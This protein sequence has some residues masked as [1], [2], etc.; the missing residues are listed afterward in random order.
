MAV[1][2]RD[3]K[4]V[5]PHTL[6]AAERKGE[7]ELFHWNERM[8]RRCLGAIDA[9]ITASNYEPDHYDVTSAAKFILGIYGADR[10]NMVLA[11]VV[12]ENP[13]DRRYDH[14]N[15]EWARGIPEPARRDVDLFA[16]T[17]P[18]L[19][20]GFIDQIRE[21]QKASVLDRLDK[22]GT[23]PQQAER[24]KPDKARPAH[25]TRKGASI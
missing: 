3:H 5:Y 16:Q 15:R 4:A 2:K 24:S 20:N 22:K 14:R 7:T 17:H 18:Y 23:G 9:A 6:E 11:S 19:L 25:H 13:S 21:A 12:R 8:N 1:V 10:V